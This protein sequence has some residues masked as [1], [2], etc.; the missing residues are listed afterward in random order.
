MNN[1]I[2]IIEAYRARRPSYFA[3][4]P[5]QLIFA[6]GAAIQNHVLTPKHGPEGRYLLTLRAANSFR[7][8]VKALGLSLVAANEQHAANTLSA[9]RFPSGVDGPKLIG[10]IKA[11]NI[12]VAGGLHRDIKAQYFRVGHM[13]VSVDE[14]LH[15]RATVTAIEQGL[16]A[17]G[18]PI[19]PGAGVAAFDAVWSS[20]L[21]ANL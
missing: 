20:S 21:V 1:W 9:I 18:L 13:G 2:P 17:Q 10:A 6:L 7:A 16:I 14:P 11:H 5:V 4:P 12:V 8:A 15:L 19:P 3:T